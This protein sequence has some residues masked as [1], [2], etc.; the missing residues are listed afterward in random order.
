VQLGLEDFYELG[1]LMVAR[2]TVGT[3]YWLVEAGAA[4]YLGPL[5]GLAVDLLEELE[6]AWLTPDPS[7]WQ[8]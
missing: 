3:Y 6:P 1:R 4:R 5:A 7:Y 8:A 2:D